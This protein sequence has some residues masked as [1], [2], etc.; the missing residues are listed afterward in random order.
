MNINHTGRLLSN[1][2]GPWVFWICGPAEHDRQQFGIGSMEGFGRRIILARNLVDGESEDSVDLSIVYIGIEG[3]ANVERVQ[4][5]TPPGLSLSLAIKTTSGLPM[6]ST[7]IDKRA[8]GDLVPCRSTR[9]LWPSTNMENNYILPEHL[10]WHKENI[11]ESMQG[12][13]SL[14]LCDLRRLARLCVWIQCI[15]TTFHSRTSPLVFLWYLW[16]FSSATLSII[17]NWTNFLG[18]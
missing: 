3:C 17:S 11:W 1:H 15:G 8:R 10:Q 18:I 14:Y 12:Q 7:D 9:T 13:S 4:R 5:I 6:W 2:T 16:N